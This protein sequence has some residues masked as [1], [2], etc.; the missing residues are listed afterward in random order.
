MFQPFHDGN[1]EKEKSKKKL[2]SS[3][4]YIFI[5]QELEHHGTGDTGIELSWSKTLTSLRTSVIAVSAGATRTLDKRDFDNACTNKTP[6]T[7]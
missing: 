5:W 4:I 1:L 7:L 2:T 3:P 6:D